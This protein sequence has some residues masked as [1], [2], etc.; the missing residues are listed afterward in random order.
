MPWG[1]VDDQHYRHE[2]VAELDDEL[3]KGCIALFWLTI[4]WCN[5]RLT[6]GRVPAGTVR[7]LGGE[8]EEASELVRVGLWDRDGKA[9]RVHD[10]LDFNKSKAQVEAERVQRAIAGQAGAKARWRPASGP[11]SD[12]DGE[13]PSEPTDDVNDG[14]DAPVSRTPSPVTPSPAP[15]AR[16]ERHDPWDDPEHE[17][18]VWLAKH[19]CDVRPGNGYHRKLV[20]AV[21]V[22]GVNALIGMMDRLADAGTKHGDVKGFLFGAIDALDA[23]GRPSLGDLDKADRA[24]DERRAHQAR[25]ERTRRDTAALRAV[26]EKQQ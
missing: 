12:A 25:L 22:H 19:G 2:K 4:S 23:R 16:A 6:D 9:Y 11:V 1:R 26:L 24:D 8:D 5:D 21:E 17:A 18:L 13:V 7:L 3:R 14:S 10:F 20:T 15:D